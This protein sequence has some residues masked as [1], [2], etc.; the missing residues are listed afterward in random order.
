MIKNEVKEP[1]LGGWLFCVVI[2]SIGLY[3]NMQNL[4]DIHAL[5]L[6]KNADKSTFFFEFLEVN[7][8]VLTV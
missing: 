7:Q 6:K 3:R 4:V 5:E 1:A 8:T 2:E